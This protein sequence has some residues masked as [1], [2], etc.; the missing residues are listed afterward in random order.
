MGKDRRRVAYWLLA[1]P[2]VAAVALVGGVAA[3]AFALVV[4]GAQIYLFAMD[5]LRDAIRR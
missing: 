2:P 4:W 3:A 5:A 1:A